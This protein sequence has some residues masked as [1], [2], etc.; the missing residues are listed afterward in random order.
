MSK[1]LKII[2]CY[3]GH[4]R[5]TF[6]TPR[7]MYEYIGEMI[8]NEIHIENGVETDVVFVNN[9][10]GIIEKN[11]YINSFNNHKTKNGKIIVENRENINGSFGAYYDMAIKYKNYY[12][13]F[14]F[15]EDDV[16]IYKENYMIDFVEFFNS[17]ENLGFVSLA[18]LSNL[19]TNQPLHS[20]GGCGLTSKE[21]FL[22]I[23]T[24]ESTQKILNKKNIKQTDLYSQLQML[25]MS[26]TNEYV[27]GGMTI[28]NHPKFSPL[29]INYES[30]SGQKHYSKFFL[31]DKNLE[32]IYKVGN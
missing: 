15:C 9:D 14:F 27:R 5:T 20:G 22:K 8:Q 17:D 18:P 7:N 3:F 31:S 1:C 26:F 2:C 24:E 29:C 12:D 10:A 28:K 23:N 32:F 25:E 11:E 13:Y 16:L 30:H 6:N 21:T 19:R 4:R